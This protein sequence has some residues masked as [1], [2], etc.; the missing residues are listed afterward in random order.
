MYDVDKYG[1]Y[2]KKQEELLGELMSYSYDK[3]LSG[4]PDNV[5]HP[6][7]YNK[8]GV[9]CIDAIMAAVSDL[10]GIEGYLTG[11]AIKYLYRWKDKNGTEDLLKC[12]WYVERLIS[13]EMAEKGKFE[14]NREK[15]RRDRRKNRRRRRK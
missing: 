15:G 4:R 6:S 7:H 14:Q 2:L 10:S 1:K 11:N 9:E 5:N 12:Y 3:L 8:G 13:Y